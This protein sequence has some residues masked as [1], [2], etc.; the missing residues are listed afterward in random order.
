MFVGMARYLN[1]DV[2]FREVEVPPSWGMRGRLIVLSHHINVSV[3]IGGRSFVVD[4]FPEV[5]ATEI[6]GR[7]IPDERAFAHFF[8]NRAAEALAK[9]KRGLAL[10]YCIK[11][12]QWDDSVPFVWTNMGVVFSHLGQF[13]RAENSYRRAIQLDQ[14]Y[15]AAISNLGNLLLREGRL[16]EAD[17][18][19]E[20]A[21]EFRNRNP[22]FHYSL[23]EQAL[24]SGD[25]LGSI[26]HFEEALKRK[27][28][29]HNFHFALA[30]AYAGLGDLNQVQKNLEKALEYAPDERGRSR[31]NQKLDILYAGGF[32][33]H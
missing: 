25:Y 21:E 18:Y 17:R 30:R 33:H 12:L 1:L 16:D 14:E 3:K 27:K 7:A 28:K 11:A 24:E 2:A 22:Y 13:E 8:N 15:L 31:Y 32:Q 23:G 29:E 10:E 4:L 26:R 5:N 20:R 9:G 19:L 6:G